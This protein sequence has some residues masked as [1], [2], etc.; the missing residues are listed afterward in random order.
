[1]LLKAV[2]WDLDGTLIDSEPYWHAGEMEIAKAH[3]GYWDEQ[4]AWSCSGTPLAN[5]AAVIRAHG[6]DL[7]P[8]QIGQMMVDYV[9]KRELEHLPW[10]P[11][12]L[13]VLASLTAA[14]V[15][16]VLV[17]TSPR[18][19]AQNVVK[20]AP[21]GA[22]SGFICGDDDVPNKPD[23]APYLAAA[24]MLGI[25]GT[26]AMAHCIALE[27][28]ITGLT[29]AVASGATTVAQLA[30]NRN[31]NPDGPQFASLNG[32]DGVTAASLDDIVRR[33]IAAA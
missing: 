16:S 18:V 17:T 21:A 23:P 22:F 3:G 5:C 20:Q 32:F 7:P 15:P 14:G 2:F 29:S 9:T 6:T 10:N 19:L 33:R 4:L 30:F 31:A 25:E 26:D 1:M 28:S 8:E 13:D 24:K 11:G 12:V 27:D